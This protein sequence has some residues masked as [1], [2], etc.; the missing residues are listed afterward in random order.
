MNAHSCESCGMPIE[1][2]PYCT[3][4]TDES[5]MLQPFTERYERM[6]AWATGR[7]PGASA[8]EIRAQTVAYMSTMPAWKDHP[9]LV[10]LRN[11]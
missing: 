3:Y 10:A 2:G 6:K 7:N 9:E 5:G 4:C 11:E 8:A 1:S